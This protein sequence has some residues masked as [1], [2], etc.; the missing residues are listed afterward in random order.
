MSDEIDKAQ[1]REQLDREQAL[2]AHVLKHN[3]VG[4]NACEECDEPISAL[5]RNLG[6]HRCIDCQQLYE[7]ARR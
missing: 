5:R 1:E 7:R 3:S 2:K 4:L 6:A